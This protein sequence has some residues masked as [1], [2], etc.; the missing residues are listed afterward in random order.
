MS[1]FI[2]ILLFIITLIT[3]FFWVATKFINKHL[4][5]NIKYEYTNIIA[6]FFPIFLIVFIIRAFIYE[7]FQIPSGSMI[8]TLL[9]GD[10]I[11]VKKFSYGLKDPIF[12]TKLI[13]F[14]NPKRG[15]IIVFRYPLNTNVLY[16][17]RIIG[18]P[19][20]N[21]IYNYKNKHLLI[22]NHCKKYLFCNKKIIIN[23]KLQSDIT[24]HNKFYYNPYWLHPKIFKEKI[25]DNLP[26][27][28]LLIDQVSDSTQLYFKQSNYL[29]GSWVVPKNKY[30][31]MGDNRDNSYDSR[32]WGFV[33]EENI[34]GKATIIWFSFKKEENKWPVG[35]RLNRIGKIQ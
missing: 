2:I 11:L 5:K 32:Y 4:K 7:P 14:N 25:D 28:I 20:D 34:V 33:P 26:Y 17:K 8:P 12:H 21:I 35:L 27:R 3:G 9:I 24:K 31:V 16:I 13:N 18:L 22:Y 19:G 10:F 1:Q 15:D 23:Y 29:S 6:S 30:F